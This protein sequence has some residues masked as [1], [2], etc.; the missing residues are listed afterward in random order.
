MD[1]VVIFWW[2]VCVWCTCLPVGV[3]LC[4]WVGHG[5]VWACMFVCACVQSVCVCLLRMALSG[6]I[7]GLGYCLEQPSLVLENGAPAPFW[8]VP[9]LIHVLQL[10][11]APFFV[12]CFRW[13]KIWWTQN[14]FYFKKK[15]CVSL[16]CVLCVCLYPH[17]CLFTHSHLSSSLQQH[18]PHAFLSGSS[19]DS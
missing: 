19:A 11:L 7:E 18:L 3:S 17:V 12:W 10:T 16:C 6:E 8:C 2:L 15:I 14:T 4:F 5:F 13:P 9:L 1:V